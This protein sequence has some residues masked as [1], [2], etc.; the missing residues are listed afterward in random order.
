MNRHINRRDYLKSSALAVVAATRCAFGRP[1]A[2]TTGPTARDTFGLLKQGK[3]IPV[4]FDTDIGGDID[5]T[6]A[7]TMLLKSPQLD[8]KLVAADAGNTTYRGR[9]LAKMLETAGRTDVPVALGIAPG[10]QPGNQSDWI[11]GY[12]LDRYRGTV[13][14]DGVGAIIDTIHQ[15]ADPLTVVCI[16]AVP[17]VE[18][19]LKRDPGIVKNARFVGM[20]GSIR[21]GYG[22]NPKP[23]PEAN[24]RNN[25]QALAATFQAPWDCT[26]T[27]LDTC[28][29]V[30][31]KG[32]RYQRVYRSKDPLVRALM[33]NY[34]IWNPSW[35]KNRP[36]VR[37]ASTTLFDTVAVY[38]AFSQDLVKMEDLPI[39][40]TDD[41]LTVIDRTKREVHCATGWRD[42]EAFEELLVE[43]LTSG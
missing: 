31:L 26:I 24:V 2:A 41:G 23:A 18:A 17:N 37:R 13:H 15:S 32:P 19:A 3:K 21:L 6:W 29:L 27:P 12:D 40:V 11:E 20:H 25:P 33:E 43:T 34:R 38:L 7:L 22:G 8:V 4:I 36:D 10:N 39:G 42:R 30:R 35:T 5:D 28:G 1:P 14:E 9:I 16:G